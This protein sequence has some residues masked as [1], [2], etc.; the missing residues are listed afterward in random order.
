MK[1][2]YLYI[3]S[4]IALLATSTSC[5]D[6]KF[7]DSFLEKP[8]TTDI[9]IDTVFAHRKYAEQV[10]TEVYHSLPDFLC[11]DG[12]LAWGVLDAMTDIGDVVV[13][14]NV[15]NPYY[16]GQMSSATSPGWM[17]Y[18][19]DDTS[20]NAKI[21]GP[22]T[23]CRMAYIFLENVDRVPDMTA[24]EKERRKAEAKV[25]IAYHYMD[26]LRYYGGMPW[27]DHAYTAEDDMKFVRM[28]VEEHV[29]KIVQ[30][31]DEAAKVLPWHVGENDY[32]RMTAAGALALKNRTLQFA[33]S[34]L[35]NSE[36]PYMEGAAADARN[37]WYGNYDP[38]RWQNAL[39][40]GLEFLRE[41]NKN[42]NYYELV[43]TGDPRKDFTAGYYDRYTGET[44]I[45]SNRFNRMT[46]AW[47]YCVSVMRWG[48]SI[49]SGVYG[50]MFETIKGEAFDWNNPLH[51]AHP[52][53]DADGNM[54]RDPR[55]YET[56]WVNGDKFRGRTVEM[57]Q[58]GRETWE[59]TGSTLSMNFYDGYGLRKF[60]L[61]HDKELFNHY[62]QCPLMRLSEIY[63]DI[64]EAMNELDKATQKDEFGRDAYDYINLVR[65]RV[66]MPD[67]TSVKIAPG[68]ALRE[69][70]LHERVVEFGFEDSRYFDINRWKKYEDWLNRDYYRL[71]AYK[72]TDESM[73]YE[74]TNDVFQP[75]IWIERWSNKYYLLPIYVNE[76]NKKY[77]LIQN[78]GWE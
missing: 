21:S 74:C 22:V 63:L 28:T 9:T 64:A 52:F 6:L 34:P 48:N 31:C 16:M 13:S 15:A 1:K 12:K 27:I 77:G 23:A 50:D 19:L 26:M 67:L 62:Y 3:G 58:G 43:K 69:A 40:S 8:I 14:S 73:R 38:A 65:N 39:D 66:N 55:L 42:G 18:R 47:Y 17:P 24:E 4:F 37:T 33:A 46:Q 68:K 70:I 5:E 57:Y 36:K 60:A 51:A 30:L 54:T 61:D 10:L 76:V 25:I 2:N 41:N 56:L 78:P 53:F 49:P 29:N 20:D 72:N 35:F 45:N 71:K 59:G 7:G 75:R 32:G 11:M 44:L